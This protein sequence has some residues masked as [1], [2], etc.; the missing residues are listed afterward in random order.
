MARKDERSTHLRQALARQ[1]RNIQRPT[2]KLTKPQHPKCLRKGGT[3]ES[4]SD[5]A[6]ELSKGGEF[7]LLFFVRELCTAIGQIRGVLR[8]F[9]WR[10]DCRHD[11]H[12][13]GNRSFPTKHTKDTKALS[14]R[15]CFINVLRVF[16]WQLFRTIRVISV[17]GG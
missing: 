12:M 10:G 17:I 1:A 2:Q 3:Q 4:V 9:F 7:V 6:T 13:F 15:F 8:R 11:A 5:S 16:R 14:Y